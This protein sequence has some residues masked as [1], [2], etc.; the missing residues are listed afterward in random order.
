MSGFLKQRGAL[1]GTV[2]VAAVALGNT[3]CGEDGSSDRAP[4]AQAGQAGE[5]GA[6]SEGGAAGEAG[7][8]SEGD[9][10]GEAGESGAGGTTPDS[11]TNLSLMRVWDS[12][13]PVALVV[14]DDEDRFLYLLTSKDEFGNPVALSGFAFVEG[15][16]FRLV[17][18][19]RMGRPKL[20][21]IPD[22]FAVF[23]EYGT[24]EVQVD[25]FDA[26]GNRE[27]FDLSFEADDLEALG[28]VLPELNFTEKSSESSI[29]GGV[30]AAADA[31]DNTLSCSVSREFLSGG[32]LKKEA[33][34][35]G[36]D[37]LVKEGL[38]DLPAAGL[39]SG[40]L[41]YGALAYS[42]AV[43][44]REI[45]NL[46]A[47]PV[48]GALEAISGVV[49]CG[50]L[51]EPG[52]EAAINWYYGIK[53]ETL[54]DRFAHAEFGLGTEGDLTQGHTSDFSVV[55]HTKGEA[56]ENRFQSVR[57]NLS[58]L[59]IK[60]PVTLTPQVPSGSSD[61]L[62]P[63]QYQ[64]RGRVTPDFEPFCPIYLAI[65]D[66][67]FW[68]MANVSARAPSLLKVTLAASD[69]SIA[70]GSTVTL[71]PSV[72]GG[73]PSYKGVWDIFDSGP[74]VEPS[75]ILESQT[76]SFDPLDDSPRVRTEYMFTVVD[77]SRAFGLE[78]ETG[79]VATGVAWVAV[80]GDGECS[81]EEQE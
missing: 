18:V 13:S 46:L 49:D 55:L 9:A 68:W 75:P 71:S 67:E 22:A 45:Q 8:P 11:E 53:K 26:E 7:A 81:A 14:H 35:L 59:G 60:E 66:S 73:V 47:K 4:S 50:E 32:S 31:A 39:V 79:N 63:V 77:G 38:T 30:L 65:D 27:V 41:R 28:L 57:V 10:A 52:L 37:C 36:R 25:H 20:V 5:A 24:S 74:P 12:E 23:G 33:L 17:L 56:K 44:P 2:L 1:W 29:L 34:T 61:P 3:R 16:E 80:C 48:R 58:C 51:L 21:A 62:A 42:C 15:S 64:W 19:D 72:E 78:Y 54:T 43:T 70:Q 6:P 76:P 69:S 40:T